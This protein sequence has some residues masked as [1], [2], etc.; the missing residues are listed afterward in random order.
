ML[1][2]LIF[3]A[4]D[5]M[6]S[7]GKIRLA[8]RL[9][10]ERVVVELGD[11]GTGMSEEVRRRCLEP[12]FTTKGEQGTGLGLAM[13]YGIIQ[14]HQAEMQLES[15]VGVGTT[16]RFR[17]VAEEAVA[18]AQ[19]APAI[20]LA[21]PL[22]ILVVD[23]QPFICQIMA[24]Y[25][26]QDCHQAD[27]AENS[28]EALALLREKKFDLLITDQAMPDLSGG[29][30]AE[31]AKEIDPNLRVILLT[32]FGAEETPEA[33]AKAIDLVLT[34]PVSLEAMRRGLA[35][36]FTQREAAPPSAR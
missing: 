1:T 3:N 32:G 10:G 11:T 27:T 14:R 20:R 33:E 36:V 19:N 26:A 22:K 28:G 34:K 8:T 6:P 13:V 29:Q 35:S 21:Q 9:E 23:D 5:A 7:G 16:F 30:L 2:N 17:F 25:L 18:A 4:V 24:Q 15:E 12:F 31:A